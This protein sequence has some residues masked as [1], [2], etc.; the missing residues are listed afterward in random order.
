MLTAVTLSLPLTRC[1]CRASSALSLVVCCSLF[2][3]RGHPQ[4]SLVSL[5]FAP[6]TISLSDSCVCLSLCCAHSLCVAHLRARSAGSCLFVSVRLSLAVLLYSRALSY[7]R[8]HTTEHTHMTA[9]SRVHK[10]RY[11]CCCSATHPDQELNGRRLHDAPAAV[12]ACRR[13]AGGH[14]AWSAWHRPLQLWA[15]TAEA[16]AWPWAAE[17]ESIAHSQ[18][19][20][21]S[22]WLA[23]EAW[24]ALMRQMAWTRVVVHESVLGLPSLRHAHAQDARRRRCHEASRWPR[25][26]ADRVGPFVRPMRVQRA[27][28]MSS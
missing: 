26:P 22:T 7:A 12:A 6:L 20:A 21:L 27:N 28:V 13:C 11:S 24:C 16:E 18:Q 17:A 15:A 19:L 4:S 23:Q 8:A 1:R 14:S 2:P 3:L 5:S 9:R 25:W 10:R